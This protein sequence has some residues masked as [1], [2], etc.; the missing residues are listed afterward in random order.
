MRD[1]SRAVMF[2]SMPLRAMRNAMLRFCLSVNSTPMLPASTSRLMRVFASRSSRSVWFIMSN[3]RIFSLRVLYHSELRILF[4]RKSGD[5]SLSTARS[6]SSFN[7][8]LT[9]RPLESLRLRKSSVMPYCSIIASC[10]DSPY[11]PGAPLCLKLTPLP[12]FFAGRTTATIGFDPGYIRRPYCVPFDG[13]AA[14]MMVSLPY[15]P[16][17]T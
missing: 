9:R 4:R 7:S 2:S 10:D 17:P 12:G 11:R 14:S 1:S 16:F 6:M 15:L 3:W 8:P 13:E 5:Q